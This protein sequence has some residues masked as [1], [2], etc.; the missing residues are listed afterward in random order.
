MTLSR[1][2]LQ[3]MINFSDHQLNL[4]NSL[5]EDHFHKQRQLE[6]ECK[7]VQLDKLIQDL[8]ADSSS[9]LAQNQANLRCTLPKNF[10]LLAADST[11]I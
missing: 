9:T 11:Q 10:P 4:I 6:L 8:I 1:S 2:L 3:R 5:L 7:P